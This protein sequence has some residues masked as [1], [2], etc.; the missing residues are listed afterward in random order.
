M[1]VL[2]VN[3]GDPHIITAFERS[4]ALEAGESSTQDDDVFAVIG[5]HC[6]GDV[7]SGIG[8]HFRVTNATLSDQ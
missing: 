7:S 5:F 8:A 4:A 1:M 3:E 2:A 6:Q